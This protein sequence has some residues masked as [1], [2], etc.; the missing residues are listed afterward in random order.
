LPDI[1]ELPKLFCGKTQQK[2][3]NEMIISG[4]AC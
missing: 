1:V 2:N 4:I 3:C